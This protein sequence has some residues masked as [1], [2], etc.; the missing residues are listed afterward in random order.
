MTD[1]KL[2]GNQVAGV[3]TRLEHLSTNR[4]A[5]SKEKTNSSAVGTLRGHWPLYLMLFLATTLN[6]LD[7]QTL[8]ILAPTL[9]AE[10]HLDNEALGWLFAVFYY[11]YTLA[12]F[13]AGFILDRSNLR[14][15]YLIAVFVWSVVASATALSTGFVSLIAFRLLLGVAESPNWPAAQTIV[16]R[17]LPPKERAMGSGIFTSGT[18]VGAL[19]A[20]GLI[21]GISSLLGWRWAFAVVGSFGL[22]WCVAWLA[23]TRRADFGE[24][25]RGTG[26]HPSASPSTAGWTGLLRRRQ[27]WLAWIVAV[28]VNPCLYFSV[29]WL[30]TY[31]TQQRGVH[32]GSELGWVLTAIFIGLDCGYLACGLLIIFLSRRLTSLTG[33]RRITFLFATVLVSLCAVVPL[34]SSL[35]VTIV[36]LV[37]VNAGLGI[38]IATYLTMAQEVDPSRIST[39][40][41]LLSGCGSLIG[42]LA[43]WAVGRITK[44][45]GSFTV[46]MIAVTV[47]V[48]IAAIAGSMVQPADSLGEPEQG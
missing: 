40:T 31:F 37:A 6:Y 33:A 25:W 26:I 17:G 27:F 8:S 21:L 4:D 9:Q 46:P 20:P 28:T 3:S 22:I 14:W 48:L 12:Q 29:N 18:S 45:S 41:G 2:P 42:A 47:V 7:R 23:I 15:A 44:I 38:W 1:D 13:A 36:A 16:G 24:I 5:R 34:I 10:L 43:M 32:P 39:T 35:P 19:I 11:A 30:P